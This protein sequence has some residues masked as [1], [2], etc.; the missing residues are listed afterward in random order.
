MIQRVQ[1]LY[2]FLVVIL[3]AVMFFTPVGEFYNQTTL[4]VYELTFRGVFLKVDGTQQIL[5]NNPS[6]MSV[7]GLPILTAVILV[8]ALISIFL[9]R[10]RV[11]QARFNVFNIMLMVGYYALLFFYIWIGKQKLHA[12]ESFLCIPSSFPLISIILSAL[13]IRGIL[14]DEALVR[15]LDRLR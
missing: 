6:V 11:L 5:E 10:K 2:L 14:K 12:D 1:T 15:S 9:Y 13:A 3:S 7:W 4:K 8:I